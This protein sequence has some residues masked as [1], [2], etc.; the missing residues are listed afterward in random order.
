MLYLW[1]WNDTATASCGYLVVW[2]AGMQFLM[3]T[4][5]PVWLDCIPQSYV[6]ILTA[7]CLRTWPCLAIGS[8]SMLASYMSSYWVMVGITITGHCSCQ[9]ASLDPDTQG[10]RSLEEKERDCTP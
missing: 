10:E 5:D 1:A 6:R 2:Y 8:L 7:Q 9:E 4:P 3:S